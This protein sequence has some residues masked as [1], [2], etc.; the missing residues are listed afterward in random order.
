MSFIK[1][2]KRRKARGDTIR[3]IWQIIILLPLY[4]LYIPAKAFVS[5]MDGV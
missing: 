5:W 2:Y 4:I 1:E 3:P